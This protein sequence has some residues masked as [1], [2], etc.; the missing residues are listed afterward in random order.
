MGFPNPFIVH[1]RP[2][3]LFEP[4]FLFSLIVFGSTAAFDIIL[5]F[6]SFFYLIFRTGFA[7]SLIVRSRSSFLFSQ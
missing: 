3:F 5:C 2:S 7:N 4:I 6:F 1:S